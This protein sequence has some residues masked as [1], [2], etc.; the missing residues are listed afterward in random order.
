MLAGSN[1]L[2]VD[3][4]TA[5]SHDALEYQGSFEAPSNYKDEEKIRAY[6]A[7]KSNEWVEECPLDPLTGRICAI[8]TLLDT[9]NGTPIK[10]IIVDT[11]GQ[12]EKILL[13]NFWKQWKELN[14]YIVGHNIKN[15]DLPYIILRS[16][17]NGIE[18]L[19]YPRHKEQYMSVIDTMDLWNAGR[20]PKKYISL[21]NMAKF[22]GVG[23][24]NTTTGKFIY[25]MISNN[26]LEDVEKYLA[27]DLHLTN[28]VFN[29][30]KSYL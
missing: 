19:W 8:G 26:E 3:I 24:K 27:N 30:F 7:A 20:Y 11:T 21:N 2:V 29:M 22:F 25:Q 4:E 23:S 5:P 6:I 12:E 18:P 9:G 28:D 17:K 14:G 1:H 15:F 10:K 16:I 13:E